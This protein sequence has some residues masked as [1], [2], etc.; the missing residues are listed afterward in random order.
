MKYD[1]IDPRSKLHPGEPYFFIR[2]QDVFSPA[3]VQAYA[4]ISQ[5][6][7]S[8]HPIIEAFVAWQKANP[9]KVKLPD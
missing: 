5:R 8:I 6:H 2:A 3:A 1:H 7:K 4:S 9:E